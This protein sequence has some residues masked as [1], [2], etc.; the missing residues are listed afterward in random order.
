MVAISRMNIRANWDQKYHQ[1]Y[2]DRKLNEAMMKEVKNYANEVFGQYA[3]SLFFQYGK[4][5]SAEFT[6]NSLNN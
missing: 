2:V 6:K 3:I 5:E 4:N 1:M